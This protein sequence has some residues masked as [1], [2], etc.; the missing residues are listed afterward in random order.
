MHFPGDLF[1]D[2]GGR[3]VE[4]RPLEFASR[5]I[6]YSKKRS[7]RSSKECGVE[8]RLLCGN[9]HGRALH[10]ICDP[11]PIGFKKPLSAMRRAGRVKTVFLRKITVLKVYNGSIHSPNLEKKIINY[12][13]TFLNFLIW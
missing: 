12:E 3:H 6:N 2:H 7:E 4:L 8:G 1:E 10:D 11:N 9:N 13:Y 5:S